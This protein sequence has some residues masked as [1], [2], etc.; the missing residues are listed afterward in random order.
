MFNRLLILF[1]IVLFSFESS[2]FAL[3]EE[4]ETLKRTS[5]AFNSVAEKG[6]AAVVSVSVLAKSQSYQN[7]M[8]D[9]PYFRHFFDMPKFNPKKEAIGS[10]VIVTQKGYILTNHHVIQNAAELSVTLSDGREFE[11]ELIGSDPKTDLALL[12]ISGNQ[13]PSVTLGNSDNLKVGDWSIAVGNPFGLQSSVT[14]GIISALG[15]SGVI[16]VDNYASF[17]QTD[18]A[19]NPGNSGGALLNIDGELIGINT[20]IFSQSGGYMGIGFAVPVN[21]AKR[22]M[23]DLLSFGKVKRGM[24]GVSIKPITEQVME[25]F[26]LKTRSGALVVG[27]ESNS[28]AEMAGVK[29]DDIIVELNDTRVSDFL[30]L[31]SSISELRIGDKSTLKVLRNGRV[32]ELNFTLMGEQDAFIGTTEEFDKLGLI[33]VKNSP[34]LQKKYNLFTAKGLVIKE[35]QK[36][37]VSDKNQL[38]EGFVIQEVNG[39]FVNTVEDYQRIIQKSDIILLTVDVEGYDYQLMLRTR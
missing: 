22:V 4:L 33:V 11:A 8:Y 25:E 23:E 29:I 27:V 7:P 14:V 2:V 19:I 12:K 38:E 3:R 15:R 39:R 31:R 17:I 35:V 28:S 20:A 16:D 24:L 9:D 36:D 37:S 32:L 21:T 1:F 34:K 30:S 5:Q 18:A 13:L 6:I 10:G 26:D